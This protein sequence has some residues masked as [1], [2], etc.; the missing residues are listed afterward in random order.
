MPSDF[1]ALYGISWKQPAPKILYIKIH[2]IYTT[3]VQRNAYI[4]II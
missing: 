2:Q 1:I 4:L 3:P